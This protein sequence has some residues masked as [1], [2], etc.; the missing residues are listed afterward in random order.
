MVLGAE[1]L[2]CAQYCGASLVLVIFKLNLTIDKMEQ[3]ID[4]LGYSCSQIINF[5]VN[6]IP[7]NFNQQKHDEPTVLKALI[8]DN[9]HLLLWHRA[10]ASLLRCMACGRK[11]YT[12]GLLP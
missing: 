11:E 8:F 5:S 12:A 4:K 10:C 9:D 3:C 7:R 1:G 2:I 6:A